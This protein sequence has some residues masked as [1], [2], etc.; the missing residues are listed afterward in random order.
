MAQER[1]S[2][3]A[4]LAIEQEIVDNID[5]EQIIKEFAAAKSRKTRI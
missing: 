1:L 3:L 5:F 2:G 4:S